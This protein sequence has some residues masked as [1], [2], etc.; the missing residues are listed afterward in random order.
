MSKYHHT[1]GIS[2][3][4]LVALNTILTDFVASPAKGDNPYARAVLRRAWLKVS[5]TLRLGN[6]ITFTDAE[7]EHLVTLAKM[8]LKLGV[9]GTLEE[10]LRS[11]L[12]KMGVK[13][14]AVPA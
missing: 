13:K 9:D 1:D 4:E 7:R 10:N 3:G 8:R 5:T 14:V 11:V 6:S 12:K 2:S